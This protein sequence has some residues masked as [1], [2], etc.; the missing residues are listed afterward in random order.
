MRAAADNLT[1]VTL[2]LG[3][4]SPAIIADDISL[5]D[6][7]DRLCYAK[8]LNAGQ[9]C[10]APD[11]IL[12]PRRKM[13]SF[14]DLYLKAFSKM[15]PAL[16]NNQDYTSMHNA[17]SHTRLLDWLKDAESKGA[18]IIKS[19]DELIHDGT[20]RLPM[21]LVT[22]VTDEMKIM[23]HEL[24]GPILP[25]LPY[26]DIDEA[27]EYIRMRP[28]P[29]GLYLFTYDLALQ[30]H[31]TYHSH[32][33]SM[34]INEAL[35]QVA[36]DDIPFGGIGPSGMGQYHGHEGFLTMSKAKPV[37]RRGR[38]NTINLIHPP[39]SNFFQKLLLKWLIR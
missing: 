33:G 37:L 23:Q 29:L 5:T 31:V 7:I 20:F 13:E 14:I 39:Y 10:V 26:D 12:V 32:A 17:Q 15:Y 22:N 1:P 30:N 9:T 38:L 4:K 21:H 36:V 18:K 11:Y 2:E 8:S 35:F 34:C 16:N 24:F 19:S 27:L 3:G 28:R 6:I 25:L